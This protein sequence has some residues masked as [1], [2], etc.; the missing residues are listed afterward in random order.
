MDLP[1][2][3]Y[4]WIVL[5]AVWLVAAA[6]QKAAIQK[7]PSG[8]RL[9]HV[10][11]ALLGLSLLGFSWSPVVWLSMRFVPATQAVFASGF[12]LEIAGAAFA[13]WA[14]I[15]L[16]SNWSA[17]PSLRSDHELITSG[18]YAAT[19]HPIYTGLIVAAAGTALAIGEW[20]GIV[21]TILIILAYLIKIPHEEQLMM[22]AFPETYPKYR[23]RV[24]ALIPGVF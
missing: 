12:A 17:R 6:K 4:P 23:K 3:S 5:G 16:G 8:K 7:Q 14:R 10:A 21:G 9:V 22:Q 13:C 1:L 19:R 20:R 24:K 2:L 11:I 18:P 15:A